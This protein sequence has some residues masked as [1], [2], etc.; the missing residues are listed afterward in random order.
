[1]V[2]QTL[3]WVQATLALLALDWQPRGMRQVTI[4][5]KR[6]WEATMRT[7]IALCAVA[8]LFS[9]SLPSET[10]E[11]ASR[12]LHYNVSKGSVRK[13][14][15]HVGSNVRYCV[16]AK[17][18]RGRQAQFYVRRS[19]NGHVKNLGSHR[20][21]SCWSTGRGVYIVYGGAHRENLK[22]YIQLKGRGWH[23]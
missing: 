17:N 13:L 18:K 9:L 1:M 14:A 8:A 20:G 6:T 22:I 3:R 4:K 23:R 10:A 2:N 15:T 11:A 12:T 21:R 7:L 19:S 5:L 16:W